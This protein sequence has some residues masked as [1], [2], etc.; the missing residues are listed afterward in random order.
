MGPNRSTIL[1]IDDAAARRAGI[2]LVRGDQ[3]KRIAEQFCVFVIDRC[4]TAHARAGQTC[5]IV[6]APDAGLEYGQVALAL[7]IVQ[8]GQRKHCFKTSE[9]LTMPL[10]DFRDSRLDPRC[11]S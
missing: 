10:R 6:A 2:T 7:L 11:E 4:H 1:S 3:V 9:T 8:A 5:R